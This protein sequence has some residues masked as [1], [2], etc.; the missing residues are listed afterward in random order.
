LALNVIISSECDSPSENNFLFG[1]CGKFA[2]DEL[3]VIVRKVT[4]LHAAITM[5]AD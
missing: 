2:V 4:L 5:F 1:L 3:K